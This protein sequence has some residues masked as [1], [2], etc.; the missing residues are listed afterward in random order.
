[1]N[2]K[3]NSNPMLH[4]QTLIVGQ[5]QTNC[6]LISDEKTSECLIVD[7]GDDASYLAE[8]MVSGKLKPV[9]ICAT[10]GH[11]DHVLGAFELQHSLDIPFSIH[12]KDTFLL[13]GMQKSAEHYL[14]IPII[15]PPPTVSIELNASTSFTIG[16]STFT[17]LETPGHTPGGVCFYCQKENICFTGDTVFAGGAIGDWRHAYSDK[18]ALLR[19]V[20]KILS[21]PSGTR[22]YPGHGEQTRVCYLT[23]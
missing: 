23:P 8:K 7:P 13:N 1:M 15:E 9:A 22:L 19:S 10:H 14:H 17:V 6:Y 20:K 5:L 3:R 4:V 11:F 18:Q 21:L 16:S 2:L 12:P